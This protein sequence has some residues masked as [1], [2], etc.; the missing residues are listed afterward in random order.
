MIDWLNNSM[1]SKYKW[2]ILI[3]GLA[4]LL[5]LYQLG[6][7]S[8]W[9]DEA[10]TLLLASQPIPDLISITATDVHPPLY[11]LVVKL[12]MGLGQTEFVVRLVSA[13]CG[14][15]SVFMLY[16]AGKVLFNQQT[17]LLGAFIM[18]IA[19]L[20]LFYAQEARM[21]TMLLMLT[22][23]S[24]WCF[25]LAL[26]KDTWLWWGLFIVGITLA[27]YTAYF[28]FFVI[29]AMGIYVLLFDRRHKQI[30]HFLIALG[31]ITILYLPWVNVFLSQTRAVFDTYWLSRPNLLIIFPTL[32]AFFTSYTLSATWV[33][34]SLAAVLLIIFIVFNDVRH[35]LK[36]GYDVQ[37][38]T[39]LL[40]WGFVPLFGTLLISLYKPIFQ[41]R[42][43][44]TATPAL[45][46]LIAWGITRTR[47]NQLNL[48]FFLPTLAL[49]LLSTFNFYFNPI[50]VK[51]AWREAA[52]YVH[53]QTQNGDV[54]LHTSTGSFLPFL[55]YKHNVRHILLPVDP[56]L[57]HQNAPSQPII[58]AVG[59]L[60]QPID[61]AVQGYERA[62][63]VVGLDQSVEHQIAQKER[64]DSRFEL[65]EETKIDGIYIFTYALD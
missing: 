31:V 26:Q 6:E 15:I 8:F 61:D 39:W 28:V 63:L 16:L 65:L 27:S 36:Q 32:A 57:A 22:I 51:P 24:T 59:A 14:T 53:E 50:F 12:F 37:S 55:A 38:L 23:F 18:A 35:A 45:Y 62:W 56:E 60:P 3:T 17:A 42:V 10:L 21:Y 41:L 49:M 4:L 47:H 48:L 46:L 25:I 19:P 40:L 34:V 5:R 29:A 43:V 9:H 52:H 20:Q 1:L 7:W 11:F 54:V 64:F 30:I 13:L 44:L 58:A 2:I 33:A